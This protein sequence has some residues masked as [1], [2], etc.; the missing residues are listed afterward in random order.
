MRTLDYGIDA[1]G[2]RPVHKLDPPVRAALR[3]GAYQLGFLDA[4]APHAI[5][6]EAVEL[7]REAGL[8][9]AVASRTRS[10]GGSPS[11]YAG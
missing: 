10:C 8:E 9:R 4:A 2:R 7:V 1:L 6:N 3:T 5:V 11:G